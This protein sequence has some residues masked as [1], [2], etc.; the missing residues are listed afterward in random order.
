VPWS[1]PIKNIHIINK[2]YI[3]KILNQKTSADEMI[4]RVWK[5]KEA[6]AEDLTKK[7]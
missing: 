1:K 2:R 6:I 4:T 5:M 3:S 7:A